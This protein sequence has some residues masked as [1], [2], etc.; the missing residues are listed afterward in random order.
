MYRKYPSVPTHNPDNVLTLENLSDTTPPKVVTNAPVQTNAHLSMIV[1]NS[2]TPAAPSYAP[3]ANLTIFGLM[4][5]MWSGSA[6]KSIGEMVKLVNFLKSDEFKK[7]DW[8]TLIFVNKPPNL[9]QALKMPPN[10]QA[11]PLE[12]GVRRKECM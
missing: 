3:F 12:F 10:Q 4:N 7:E 2:Q 9:M 11:N 8:L 5:W 6:M 1:D